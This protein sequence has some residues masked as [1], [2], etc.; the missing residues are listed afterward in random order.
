MYSSMS[1]SF[2]APRPMVRRPVKPVLMPNTMRPGASLFS[3]AK[4]LAATGA[5]RLDGIST[6]VPSLIP[7]GLHR[8]RRHGDERIG[9]QHL[10][11]EEPGVGEAEFLRAAHEAP[12]VGGGGDGD[13]ELHGQWLLRDSPR[14]SMTL[15]Y[16]VAGSR[17]A[18]VP[19]WP[20]ME[21]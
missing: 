11:V 9:A 5:M 13:A 18:P 19:S 14:V 16:S 3:E 20:T 21:R 15:R 6:P 7:R 17:H 2:T 1:A 10:G 4:A 12:G 8:R